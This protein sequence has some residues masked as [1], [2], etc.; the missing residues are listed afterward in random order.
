MKDHDLDPKDSRL[1]NPYRVLLHQLMGTSI[2]RPRMKSAINIW[3]R[4]E[5]PVIK[6]EVQCLMLVGG[7]PHSEVVTLRERVA[8]KIFLQL[9]EEER[10]GW[11]VQAKEEH[12]V[13]IENWRNEMQ[14]DPS[15]E[16]AA[17][18]KYVQ[19]LYFYVS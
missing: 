13:A 18:Q 7:I 11:G 1:C 5:A 3:H 12:E 4:T 9:P 8:K 10:K 16:P 17:R 6:A 15:E 14:A 2:Q 19:S